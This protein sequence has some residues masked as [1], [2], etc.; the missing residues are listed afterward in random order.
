MNTF[1]FPLRLIPRV[2]RSTWTMRLTPVVAL[3]M[4]VMLS[5]LLFLIQGASPLK[6][7]IA[8]VVSPL[9]SVG[10]IAEVLLKAS[11]LCITALGMA[12]AFRSN[13]NNIGAEGQVI[14]GGI[15]AATVALHLP[16]AVPS[17]LGVPAVLLGGIIGGALWSSVP[18]GLR[19][20]FSVNETLSSLLLVYVAIQL[21]SWLTSGPWRDPQG[22]NFPETE[23]F[24]GNVT[25]PSLAH[26]GLTFWE[27]TRLNIAVL[28]AA[29]SVAATSLFID[30]SR[31]GYELIVAGQSQ[32]AA[33]YA[34]VS[35]SM[36]VWI[37]LLC[38]GGAAGL[39]GALEVSGSLGQ[40]QAGWT[41]GYGF[42]A[43]VAAYL[44]RL[45]PVSIAI[46]SGLLAQIEIGSLNLQMELGLPSALSYLIQG[47]LLL[48]IL[49]M[50]LMVRYDVQRKM[51][52]IR[53]VEKQGV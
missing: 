51:L 48:S 11:P 44:G 43:I 39:A 47:F 12:V 24:N 5:V 6:G 49:G 38:S 15:G 52:P 17:Y 1:A 14:L 9:S 4:T 23:L 34:G 21:M 37:P 28:I 31:I 50:D 3:M 19:S 20:K 18:A 29:A 36:S 30:R 41:P 7:V 13:V 26:L 10:G 40:L 27:G 42:T 53:N 25:L 22:L 45:K 32:R 8:L 16:V 2:H 46:S 35:K 33:S